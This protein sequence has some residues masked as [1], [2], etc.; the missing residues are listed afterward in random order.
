MFDSTALLQL[1]CDSNYTLY[2]KLPSKSLFPAQRAAEGETPGRSCSS[3]P[4]KIPWRWNSEILTVRNTASALDCE[5]TPGGRQGQF[6]AVVCLKSEELK[7]EVDTSPQ[8]KL[9]EWDYRKLP[10]Q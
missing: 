9:N 2:T 4:P 5:V 6:E 7:V 10:Y 3:T 1:L 8:A